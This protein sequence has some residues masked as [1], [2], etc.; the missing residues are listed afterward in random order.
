MDGKMGRVIDVWRELGE[1]EE[2]KVETKGTGHAADQQ[3]IEEGQER[4]NMKRKTGLTPK[5]KEERK[6]RKSR[7]LVEEKRSKN[8]AKGKE[9][10]ATGKPNESIE[11]K[12]SQQKRKKLKSRAEL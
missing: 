12:S 1:K 9:R 2:E 4:E 10:T 11:T 6:K 8:I 3:Q 5:N 7:K